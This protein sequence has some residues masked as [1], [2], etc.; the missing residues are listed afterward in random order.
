MTFSVE[1]WCRNIVKEELREGPLS[2]IL[3]A[4]FLL[5][6]LG[7]IHLLGI[8]PI[9]LWKLKTKLFPNK[10]IIKQDILRTSL[11]KN[12]TTVN[13]IQNSLLVYSLTVVDNFI[14]YLNACNRLKKGP[15][16]HSAYLFKGTM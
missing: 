2:K 13:F 7:P 10:I 12:E 1:R 8:Q 3:I 11:T 4:V 5:D 9:K 15:G 16:L 14:K 6:Y